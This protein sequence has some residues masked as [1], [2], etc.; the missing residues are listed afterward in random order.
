MKIKTPRASSLSL[1]IADKIRFEIL[2]GAYE[3][4]ARI[5]SV[6]SYAEELCVN[7]NTVQKALHQ[8]TEE[9][10]LQ[11]RSTAGRVI[12]DDTELLE[13]LRTRM[14]NDAMHRMCSYGRRLGISKD[15][16]IS[17]INEHYD[18]PRKKKS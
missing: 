8:L 9:G 12:T 7:P 13:G 5:P 18:A 6:R 10:V 4:G 11:V 17:L 16:M 1:Q 14:K 2:C 15:E 3:P